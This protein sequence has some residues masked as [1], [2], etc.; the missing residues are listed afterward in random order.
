MK[1]GRYFVF[2]GGF[3]GGSSTKKQRFCDLARKS[4]CVY[5]TARRDVPKKGPF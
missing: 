1:T 5:T 4:S 3:V 2:S